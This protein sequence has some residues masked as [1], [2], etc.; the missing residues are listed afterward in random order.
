MKETRASSADV[1]HAAGVSRTTV[2][3]VLNNTP[4]KNI[5]EETRQRV[6]A[7]ARTLSYIP[8]TRARSVAMIKHHSIGF[9]IPHAGYISSDAH[10]LRVIEGMTPVLNKARFQLVL[11]PLKYSEVNYLQL[12][13]QDNVDGIILMNV[14][15]GD[16]GLHEVIESGLPTV[17]IGSINRPEV[18]QLDIDNVAAAATAVRYL[19]TLGHIDIAMIVHAPLSYYAARGRR[20][21][22]SLAMGEAGLP[23]Q[24]KWV[25]VANFTEQSG[26]L[27]MQQILGTEGRPSAVFAGNDVIA[28]GALQAIKDAGLTVP[29]DISL[30]GFDDD[31]LS[32][33]M[34]PPLTTI[35]N[36]APGLGA[37]AAR[38]LIAKLRG[39]YV[40]CPRSILAVTLTQRESCKPF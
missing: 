14:H 16:T 22:Y 9:F 35:T 28:Y 1:A 38:L 30:I 27:A 15:D 18:C 6:L 7:A 13:R 23:I 5:P 40:P 20:E 8:N 10:I 32:R 17:V 36:P 26:Y 33:Y 39:R 12:A 3:F 37:E 19:I 25:R 11:Q 2:S 31:L 24:E 34:N 4:G 29:D 21:G